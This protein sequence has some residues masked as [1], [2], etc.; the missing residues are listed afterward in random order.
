M[1][2]VQAAFG[3]T[4]QR[5]AAALMRDGKLDDFLVDPPA[6]AVRTAA[7]YRARI[8]RPVKGMG[9]AFV[10]IGGQSA[11]LRQAKGLAA[12]AMITVQVTGYAEPGKAP[13]VTTRVL[14][15]S[16]YCIITPGAQGRNISRAIAD[17]A[18]RERLQEALQELDLPEDA[19]LI[20][21]TACADVDPEVILGDVERT[22]AIAQQVMSD[23][24]TTAELLLDGP[25]AHELGWR[26]WTDVSE[27]DVL[28][29]PNAFENL[30]I[31]EEI[32]SLNTPFVALK[33]GASLFIEPTRALVAIDVNTGPATDPA[34]GLKA[35]LAAAKE[36]PRGLRLR[37]LGGQVAIDFAP[38]ARKDRRQVET[39]L[40]AAFRTDPV[41]TALVGWTPLG[42]FEL[43][44]KR[45]RLPVTEDIS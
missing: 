40:K 12:G 9:G 37:G 2:G 20:L 44:R 19:G 10:D 36:I 34:S 4:G 5:K 35:N 3:T 14:F 31:D 28:E 23:R 11:F 18:E 45:E 13:P 32:A 22:A 38:M 24:S 25:D 43:Q 8:G 6:N 39:A 26:E 17:E 41:D 30:G 15:K 33:N 27:A 7:I 42:L 21:R 1:K 29:S 16:R